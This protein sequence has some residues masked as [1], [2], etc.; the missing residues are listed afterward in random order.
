MNPSPPIVFNDLIEDD[1]HGV[2]FPFPQISPCPIKIVHIPGR[3]TPH[4][5]RCRQTQRHSRTHH[6][7]IGF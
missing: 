6:L 1:V 7:G 2:S 3:R 5:R 4:L